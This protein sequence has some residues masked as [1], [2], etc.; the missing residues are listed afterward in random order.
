MFRDESSK[1]MQ[2]AHA[3][4]GREDNEGHDRPD[5]PSAVTPP[6]QPNPSSSNHQSP[7]TTTLSPASAAP[8]SGWKAV[9]N[10]APEPG[11]V[12]LMVKPLGPTWAEQG[13]QFYINRYVLGYGDDPKCPEDL[14]DGRLVFD[15]AVQDI[16][17]AIGLIAMSNLTGDGDTKLAARQNYVLALRQLGGSLTNLDTVRM[18][19]TLRSV[20]LLALF[21]VWTLSPRI[22]RDEAH[23]HV[24]QVVKTTH[25]TTKSAQAHIMGAAALVR[26]LLPVRE[27][28]ATGL[29]GLVQLCYA[30]VR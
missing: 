6:L 21:E 25:E 4:W 8:V 17:A 14:H 3:K 1:V 2:R 12:A 29:R 10:V 11:Q 5:G 20:V 19:V 16:M 27:F 24:S 7:S 23:T 22:P 26:S 15:P 28:P 18:D 13:V 9:N 30:L